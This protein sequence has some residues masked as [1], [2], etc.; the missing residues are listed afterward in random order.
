VKCDH[1][2]QALKPQLRKATRINHHHQQE[3]NLQAL[4]FLK[5]KVKLLVTIKIKAMIKGELKWRQLKKM[6]LELIMMMPVDQ[7]NLNHKC[8]TQESIKALNGIIPLT[9]YL[10]VFKEG[11]SFTFSDI[12]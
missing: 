6:Q 3:L 9:I 10:G 2:N 8:H 5:I 1:M 4:K 11:Y 7:F 12:L